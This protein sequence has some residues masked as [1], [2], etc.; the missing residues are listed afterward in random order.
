LSGKV[1]PTP[2]PAPVAPIKPPSVGALPAT[3]KPSIAGPPKFTEKEQAAM[4]MKN[5]EEEIAAA[6]KEIVNAR[7]GAEKILKYKRQINELFDLVTKND[8]G[9]PSMEGIPLSENILTMDKTNAQVKKLAEG[10]INMFSEPGQSQMMNTIVERQMQGAVVHNLFSDPQ[11]NKQ[12]AAILRSNVEHLQT[13]P[14][15][16]EKWKKSHNG[17]LEGAADA[18]IDYTENNPLYIFEKDKRGKVTVKENPHVYPWPQWLKK[19]E[20]EQGRR[21]RVIRGRTFIEQEDGS[22]MEQQ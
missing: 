11:L 13:F 15:F 19:R 1:A 18:W 22:W 14:G 10:I 3:P 7:L 12:N 2:V 4:D 21:T 9:H 6:N 17:T 8:I 16:L 5:R 20:Q